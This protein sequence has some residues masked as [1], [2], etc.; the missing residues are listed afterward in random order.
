M[1]L[2]AIYPNRWRPP[3]RFYTA[4]PLGG[5]RRPLPP[6]R[7]RRPRRVGT[8][9]LRHR[10]PR[11]RGPTHP[12]PPP[13]RRRTRAWSLAAT[14]TTTI[15]RGAHVVAIDGGRGGGSGRGANGADSP[16][17]LLSPASGRPP[18][19]STPP[20]PP[21][22]PHLPR[23]GPASGARQ[24]CPR[25][26]G[27]ADAA[28]HRGGTRGVVGPAHPPYESPPLALWRELPLHTP[29]TQRSLESVAAC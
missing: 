8:P 23:P 5:A 10:R 14:P 9:A 13:C 20:P 17:P 18:A 24:Q 3:P 4:R 15:P 19:P 6:T 26:P 29:P 12:S 2:A 22:T 25:R 16:S 7:R 11:P 28:G 21:S 27:R 1:R